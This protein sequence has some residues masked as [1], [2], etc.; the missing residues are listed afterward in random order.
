MRRPARLSDRVL[1]GII[2]ATSAILAGEHC[3]E[4]G[5]CEDDAETI[6]AADEW[7]RRERSRRAKTKAEKEARR[8]E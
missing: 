6:S 1:D 2:S 8:S 4:G 7:A 3:G 5:D